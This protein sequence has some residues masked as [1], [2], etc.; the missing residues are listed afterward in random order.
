MYPAELKYTKDHEWVRISDGQGRVG[1]TEYA[2]QQL[3]DVVFVELPAVSR[4]FKKGQVFG[5]VESVK[6]ASDLYCP[7]S[8]EVVQVN[9]DLATRPQ[10]VNEAPHETWMIA[11]KL[12]DP[13]EEKDLLDNTQYAELVKA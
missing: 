3:G 10:Q 5:V 11:L 12:S 2:Q 7:M 4:T 6:T 1:I 13:G 9:A 8:G